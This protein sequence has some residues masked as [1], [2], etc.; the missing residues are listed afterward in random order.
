MLPRRVALAVAAA[1][2]AHCGAGCARNALRRAVYARGLASEGPAP[3]APLSAYQKWLREHKDT[4]GTFSVRSIITF[5][6]LTAWE[7]WRMF[8]FV[9]Y[10]LGAAVGLGG[11]WYLTHTRSPPVAADGLVTAFEK[12]YVPPDDAT[13]DAAATVRRPEL[14]AQLLN[15]MRPQASK[16]YAVVVGAHGTGKVGG[17]VLAPTLATWHQ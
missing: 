3:Q 6:V 16:T 4:D 10:G 14:H 15:L 11:V 12:G 7:R 17:A 9:M 13:D 1:P 2:R 5:R 8:K